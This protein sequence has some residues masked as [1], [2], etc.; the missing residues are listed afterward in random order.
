M[1]RAV[2][3]II[4]SMLAF[5]CVCEGAEGR[6][7][8]ALLRLINSR[9]SGNPKAYE[10]AAQVVAD[11][12]AAGRLL[13]Q[14]VIALASRDPDAPKA[15]QISDKLREKYLAESRPKIQALAER[16]NNSLAWYLLSLEAN[17]ATLL[18]KAA[19]AGNI[20]ALNAWGTMSLV[21]ALQSPL[22]DTNDMQ[23]VFSQSYQA[24][25][26]AAD[27]GDP[28]G[29][30]NV[31][32]C[33]MNGYGVPADGNKALKCFMAA[34]ASG[35]PEA[36]NNLGGFYRDGIVVQKDPA[37][38]MQFFAKSADFGNAYGELNYAL[39]LLRGEG[40]EKDPE[41]ATNMLHSS[42]QKGNIEA[43]NAY[44]K[45]LYDA[46]GVER[47]FTEAVRWFRTAA[48]RG[49]A[50]AMENYAKCFEDG[51]GGLKRDANLATVWNV[52]ARA[53]R[54]DRNAAAWLLQNG[55]SLR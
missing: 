38:A 50:P 36:I 14:Y 13:Q 42:A 25:R 21:K 19:D 23:K 3:S 39:G 41:R 44:G 17:D 16:K 54:G 31:G 8:Q 48:E 29:L 52:R 22:V 5:A 7:H 55:H 27:H 9:S 28:N 2:F 32:M 34:A 30:Y 12:A 15:A 20:Q 18:K 11:D 40:V 53:A 35:H 33:H 47:D 51:V 46:N 37:K 10:E 45:C 4:A 26:T 1:K 49:C 43:M 6:S 24:F